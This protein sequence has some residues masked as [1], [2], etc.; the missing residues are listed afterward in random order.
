[1]QAPAQIRS[2]AEN[3]RSS[4]GRTIPEIPSLMTPGEV[5]GDPTPTIQPG[6][7]PR[8]AMFMDPVGPARSMPGASSFMD[9]VA[10]PTADVTQLQGTP[11]RQIADVA[12]RVEK[13]AIPGGGGEQTGLNMSGGVSAAFVPEYANSSFNDLLAAQGNE[14][15]TPFSSNQLPST[16]GNPFSGTAPKTDGFN[17]GAPGI[18]GNAYDNYGAAGGAANVSRGELAQKDEFNPNAARI[19]GGSSRKPG[20]SLSDALAD[21]A[22]INSY[23]DKFSSGDRER[24]ARSAFLNA[25]DSL[26]GLQARDAVNDVVYAGGQHYGRD[27]DGTFKLDRADARQVASGKAQ[28]QDFLKSKISTTVDAQK[29]TPAEAQDPLSAAGSAVKSGFAAG[30][31]TDFGLNNNQAASQTGVGPVV[32]TDQIPKDLSGAAGKKYLADLDAGRL[33]N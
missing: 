22:G 13:R 10:P 31:Q 24:A 19:E 8:G 18:T 3:R 16:A 32:P 27:G 2:R 29:Q 15:Y 28:A 11:G 30:A 1:M 12:P 6:G 33:F 21:T 14:R 23:M 9:P 7:R 17:P 4:G 26:S 25:E 5:Y 20:G